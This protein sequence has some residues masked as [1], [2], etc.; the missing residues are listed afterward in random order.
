M[1]KKILALVMVCAVLAGT[2]LVATAASVGDVATDIPGGEKTAT[3]I[4][5]GAVIRSGDAGVES[6]VQGMAT[7]VI[8]GTASRSGDAGVIGDGSEETTDG[9]GEDLGIQPRARGSLA[10]KKGYTYDSQSLY[11]GETITINATW[12]PTSSS[13]RLGLK[14]EGNGVITYKTV[15]GGSGSA[16]FDVVTSGTYSIYVYNPSST[17]VDFVV[18][19][20]IL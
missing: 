16:S 18:S 6:R 14:N 7:Y 13:M 1:K 10:S 19:Y 8:D 15:T 17:D 3:Y 9:T 12:T 4:T 2:S 5:D 11:E 20:I